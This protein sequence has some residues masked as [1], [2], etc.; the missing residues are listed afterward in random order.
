MIEYRAI[1]MKDRKFEGGFKL[2]RGTYV[3]ARETEHGWT[4]TYYEDKGS[5]HSFGLDEDDFS[6]LQSSDCQVEY[7]I[8]MPDPPDPPEK[9][10][11]EQEMSRRRLQYRIARHRETADELEKLLE[12][13]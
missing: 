1:L 11:R 2:A 5:A 12:E 13:V 8:V 7:L 9:I 4:G 10:E 6:I 3:Y